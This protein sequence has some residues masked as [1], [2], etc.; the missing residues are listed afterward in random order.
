MDF[1][2]KAYFDRYNQKMNDLQKIETG[3]SARK[4]D[5]LTNLRRKLFEL[6]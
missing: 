6:R 3:R 5:K 2:H 4:R 1:S